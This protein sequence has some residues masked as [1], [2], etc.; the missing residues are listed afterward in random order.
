MFVKPS[1]N[2]SD[3][4]Y[5]PRRS[6]RVDLPRSALDHHRVRFNYRGISIGKSSL[7]ESGESFEDGIESLKQKAENG[8]FF[9][10]LTFH[11]VLASR[12]PATFSFLLLAFCFFK[13]DADTIAITAR[14]GCF[15]R[16]SFKGQRSTMALKHGLMLIKFNLK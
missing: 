16:V 5:P 7:D 6:L 3:N 12:E 14:E 10:L 2:P 4:I 11:W 9:L 13:I 1:F 8:K 15:I